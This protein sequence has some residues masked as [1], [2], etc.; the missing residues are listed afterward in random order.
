MTLVLALYSASTTRWS[1]THIWAAAASTGNIIFP[2]EELELIVMK[3]EAYPVPPFVGSFLTVIVALSVGGRVP[4]LGV[5][6]IHSSE[7]AM[8]HVSGAA[9]VFFSV[10]VSLV[11]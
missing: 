8:D 11:L 1:R 6:D 5:T 10:K 3:P 7:A 2:V 4:E 9:P